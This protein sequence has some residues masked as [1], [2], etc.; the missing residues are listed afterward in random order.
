VEAKVGNNQFP[1]QPACVHGFPNPPEQREEKKPP[2]QRPENRGFSRENPSKPRKSLQK[3][4]AALTPGK[5]GPSL[6]AYAIFHAW[7]FQATFAG[8]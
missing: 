2:A 1:E 5:P 6:R 3:K 7:D 8:R 4:S